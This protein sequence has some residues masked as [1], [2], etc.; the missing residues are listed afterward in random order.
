MASISSSLIGFRFSRLMPTRTTSIRSGSPTC[1]Q[2]PIIFVNILKM[3]IQIRFPI[4]KYWYQNE[5]YKPIL[6]GAMMGGLGAPI[7]AAAIFL[8]VSG[9]TGQSGTTVKISKT[10]TTYHVIPT[11]VQAAREGNWMPRLWGPT[12]CT[13]CLKTLGFILKFANDWQRQNWRISF[14]FWRTDIGL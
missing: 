8:M 13:A 3:S 9:I 12:F 6:W 4:L 7:A 11:G 2:L 1:D 14:I 5:V 10:V